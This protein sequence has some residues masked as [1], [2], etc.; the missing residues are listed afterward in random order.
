M[1]CQGHERLQ[2][3]PNRRDLGEKAEEA[4]TLLAG[5]KSPTSKEDGKSDI[6]GDSAKEEDTCE[7]EETQHF[8]QSEEEMDSMIEAIS[9]QWMSRA[10]EKRVELDPQIYSKIQS[11]ASE[12]LNQ[13]RRQNQRGYCKIELN[14]RSKRERKRNRPKPS[15]C[16]GVGV[17]YQ[18]Q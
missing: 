11:A 12:A 6:K 14:K 13:T 17:S 3:T 4:A 8:D 1:G 10:Q 2:A 9:S 7:D 16:P 18:L 5:W 15:K